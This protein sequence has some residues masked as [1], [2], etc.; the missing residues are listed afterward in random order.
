MKMSHRFVLMCVI[1]VSFLTLP[2]L[3]WGQTASVANSHVPDSRQRFLDRSSEAFQDGGSAQRYVYP[4]TP[5]P[6]ES[7]QQQGNQSQGQSQN[8]NQ[9]QGMT[10]N[11]NQNQ[12]QGQNQNGQGQKK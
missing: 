10:G 11:Q 4:S 1:A 6:Q 8:G 5:K 2:M 12:N 9:N 7:S 3:T